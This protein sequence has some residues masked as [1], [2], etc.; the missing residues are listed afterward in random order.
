MFNSSDWNLFVF[1][2]FSRKKKCAF[3]EETNLHASETY[4]LGHKDT[5][6]QAKTRNFIK[7]RCICLHLDTKLY[8]NNEKKTFERSMT[9]EILLESIKLASSHCPFFRGQALRRAGLNYSFFP[10]EAHVRFLPNGENI[11]EILLK[12]SWIFRPVV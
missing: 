10:W 9:G 5:D 11:R 8:A 2:K 12:I 4:H 3:R 6:G 7:V 1:E